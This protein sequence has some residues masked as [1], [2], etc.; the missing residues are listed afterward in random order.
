[1]ASDEGKAQAK[2]AKVIKDLHNAFERWRSVQT[3]LGFK[4]WNDL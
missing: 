2:V 3:D 4:T 1:M